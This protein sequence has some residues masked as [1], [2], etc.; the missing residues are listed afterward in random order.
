MITRADIP[1]WSLPLRIG[2]FLLLAT[3]AAAKTWFVAATASPG[4]DGTA[5]DRAFPALATAIAAARP[6]DAIWVRVG[7]LEL[8]DTVRL[9]AGISLYGGFAGTEA[10]PDDRRAINFAHETVLRL[11]RPGASVVEISDG[12]DVRLDGFTLTG[13]D[14]RAALLLR[15]C[16]DTVALAHLRISGNVSDEPGA[17]VRVTERSSPRVFNCQIADNSA[18]GDGGGLYIDATSGGDWSWC[19]VNGNTARGAFGG[20]ALIAAGATPRFANCDF[21]FNTAAA[22]GSALACG[23]GVTL[24]DCVISSNLAAGDDGTGAAVRVHG[25]TAPLVLAGATYVV[26]NVRR[27][28][29]PEYA[30]GL[31]DEA[32]AEIRDAAIVSK[33]ERGPADPDLLGRRNDLHTVLHDVFAP[34]LTVGAPAPGK[35]VKQT[36]PDRAGTA[37]YHCVYLPLDW[38]PGKKFPLLVGFPGN[39]PYRNRFGDRSGGLPEDNPLGIGVTGGRGAVVLGL[40]YLESRK[41]LAPTGTWWG[42]VQATI[43]YTRDA[44]RFACENFGA[45]PAR[46]VL[47]GFSRSAIGAS[48]IGLHDDTIAPLWRAFLCYDG[49][50]SQADMTRNWYRHDQHSHGYDPRDFDGTGVARRFQRLAGRPLFILGGRGEA[51]KLNAPHG[52]PVELLAKPHR[53][54]HVSWALRDTPERAA[55]RAWLARVLA[56]PAP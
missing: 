48:F 22:D 51:E 49:W 35:W 4:G 15:R 2:L 18:A 34:P 42:D 16:A 12:R 27:R 13:A 40:G 5:W 6:G 53:N 14:G 11:R 21:Y 55:V 7:T 52:W 37:A 26:G 56:E 20:G 47:F 41:N 43:A 33:N 29:A 45:D 23:G 44:V 36:L 31:D 19:I 17:G 28:A 32:R 1:A 3:T 39:G 50:E 46:V 38:Q 54:H 9:S 25:G 8:A 24:R 30:P 10:S